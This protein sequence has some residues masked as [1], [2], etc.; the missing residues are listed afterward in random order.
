M[1]NQ[2]MCGTCPKSF[3]QPG[4]CSECYCPLRL[5]LEEETDPRGKLCKLIKALRLY[6]HLLF[7]IRAAA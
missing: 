6:G 2:W 3:S 1:K 5:F 7:K 4:D